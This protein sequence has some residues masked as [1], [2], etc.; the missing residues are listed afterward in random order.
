MRLFFCAKTDKNDL[1]PPVGFTLGRREKAPKEH[2]FKP[3]WDGMSPL[4]PM[5]KTPFKD[6][7]HFLNGDILTLKINDC[8]VTTIN[9]L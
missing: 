9:T 4:K 8:A 2:L 7:I 5:L 1:L 3:S 6:A